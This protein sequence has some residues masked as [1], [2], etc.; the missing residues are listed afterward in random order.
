MVFF[1]EKFLQLL[2]RFSYLQQVLHHNLQTFPLDRS[3]DNLILNSSS[4]FF[5][6]LTLAVFAIFLTWN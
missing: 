2:M 6:V 4:D 1:G 5:T 3:Y